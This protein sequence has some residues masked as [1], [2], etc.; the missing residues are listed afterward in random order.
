MSLAVVLQLKQ[1][2]KLMY[3]FFLS[4]QQVL[5]FASVLL[6]SYRLKKTVGS[7]ACAQG[8]QAE[9]ISYSQQLV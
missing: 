7:G 9:T 2:K 1:L 8:E 5:L 3:S 4:R 6:P